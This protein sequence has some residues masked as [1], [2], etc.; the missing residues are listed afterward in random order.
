MDDA[1]KLI[2]PLL[3]LISKSLSYHST[4]NSSTVLCAIQNADWKSFLGFYFMCT[5]SRRNTLTCRNPRLSSSTAGWLL[6][7]RNISRY[8]RARVYAWHLNAASPRTSYVYAFARTYAH[9][10]THFSRKTYFWDAI[11]KLLDSVNVFNILFTVM[12][13]VMY[14]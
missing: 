6:V 12:L 1:Q 14:V 5:T 8:M 2:A 10:H 9:T 11:Q 4:Q 13:F 3:L 7:P